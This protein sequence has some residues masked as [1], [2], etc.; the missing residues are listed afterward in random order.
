MN[1]YDFD[2]HDNDDDEFFDD[3]SDSDLE[4]KPKPKLNVA[5]NLEQNLANEP[6]LLDVSSINTCIKTL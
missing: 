2:D 6:P 5:L 3:E 4:E 1:Y